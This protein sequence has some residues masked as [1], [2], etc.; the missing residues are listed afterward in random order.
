M[1]VINK[2]N[3]HFDATLWTGDGTTSPRSI[4]NAGGFQPDLVWSK[5]RTSTYNHQLFDSVRG[6]G[7]SK[8][9]MASQTD[10]EGTNASS[11][12]FLSAFNSNGFSLTKGTDPGNEYLWVGKTS[13]NYV[14]WQWKAGGAAVANTSG[15]ISSQVSA[16]PTAGF[17]VVTY[18]GN[19][20][21]SATVGHGLGVAPGMII[22]KSRSATS[23]WLIWHSSLTAGYQLRFTTDAQEQVSSAT[24]DG[25]LGS[26]TSSVINFIAGSSNVNNVN[27]NGGTFVA[28]CWAPVA[29]YSAFGSY[30][31][32]GSA[33]GP[34][35]Y[36]G[37]RP[38]FI[39]YKNSSYASTGWAILDSS[40]D[41]FNVLNDRLFAESG[42]A[43]DTSVSPMDFTSNGFKV[44]STNDGVNR[45]SDTI[46]YMAFAEAPFKFA[47]AR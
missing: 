32:N 27:A 4:T 30:T 33:D 21:S 46:I 44:R 28:Y 9:L 6:T 24:T 39:L 15:T 36:T 23:S 35:I 38:R 31:G 34:F 2:P 3:Q 37:F 16:N 11:F 41:T 26:G 1:P 13:D 29:G 45:S 8:N 18:T 43:E 17:S 40:R 42:V 10:I 19:G 20:S 5:N 47:N 7:F 14:A 12:G 22:V 25:G